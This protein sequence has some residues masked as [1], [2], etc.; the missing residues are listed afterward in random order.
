MNDMQQAM[1]GG[2]MNT[3]IRDGDTVRRVGGPWTPTV[4]RYLRYLKRGGIDWAPE[5][6]G[7]DGTHET[8]SFIDAFVPA[9]PLPNWVWTDAALEQGARMLRQLHDASIGFPLDE[10]TWQSATK[11]PV[12]VICHNDF[13]PHNLAFDDGM[14]VGAIDFDMCSPGPR[15]WDIAYF[16]TRMVPLT[17]EP[18]VGAPTGRDVSRRIQLLI[19]AYGSDA[20]SIPLTV[21]AVVQVAIRRLYQLADFSR[22]KADELSKPELRD[23][24]DEYDRDA[25]FLL[26]T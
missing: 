20:G 19:D 2:N 24:A 7:F 26:R 15:I 9:Y 8:L 1:S 13:S 21:D 23:E 5:P 16:A 14:I 17:G 18:P 22:A 6:I 12:E 3:V 10:S 4:H 11:V 25:A